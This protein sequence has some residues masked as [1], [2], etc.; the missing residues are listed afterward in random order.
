MDA[1][2]LLSKLLTTPLRHGFFLISYQ[3]LII[4]LTLSSICYRFWVDRSLFQKERERSVPW[5]FDLRRNTKKKIKGRLIDFILTYTGFSFRIFFVSIPGVTYS[6]IDNYVSK[7]MSRIALLSQ[8]SDVT[9]LTLPMVLNDTK[10]S[11]S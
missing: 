5:F 3:T 9:H 7:L 1:T 11:G 4:P 10:S 8:S 6:S 2:V